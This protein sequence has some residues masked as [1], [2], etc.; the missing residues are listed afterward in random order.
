MAKN[1]VDEWDTTAAN[2]TDIGGIAVDTNLFRIN[3]IDNAWRELMAQVARAASWTDLGNLTAAELQQLANIDTTT[4]STAQWGYVGAMDQGVATTDSPT[5]AAAT[6]AGRVGDSDTGGLQ[7]PS[8]TDAQR[9]GSPNTGDTRH[10]SDQ[11]TIE[12]YNGSGWTQL[13]TGG[14]SWTL[15]T[16]A[17]LPAATSVSVTGLPSGID[18]LVIW[19][20]SATHDSGGNATFSI[21]LGDSGGIES[22]GYEN[23]QGTIGA[24]QSGT[25]ADRFQLSENVANSVTMNSTA[26]IRRMT[27]NKFT[28]STQTN[29]SGSVAYASH[30]I[31]TL[32]AELD[33][34]EISANTGSFDGGTYNYAYRVGS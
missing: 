28:C 26:V 9:P 1:E 17:S 13:A 33:R 29:T 34:F 25:N 14:G 10:S 12:F 21:R 15:G 32:S 4:I 16:E 24:T 27:G 18:E 2:N 30:G 3:T 31:K 23:T 22:S 6:V 20:D 8:G 7:L 5:F 19:L 11:A